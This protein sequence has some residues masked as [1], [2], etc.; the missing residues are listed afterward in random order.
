MFIRVYFKEFLSLHIFKIFKNLVLPIE[1]FLTT[2]IELTVYEIIELHQLS[3]KLYKR[4]RRG[5]RV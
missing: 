3:P 5:K 4:F 1:N 2:P